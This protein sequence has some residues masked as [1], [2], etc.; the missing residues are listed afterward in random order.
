MIGSIMNNVIRPADV[1]L[2]LMHTNEKYW[3]YRRQPTC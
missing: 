2:F 3:Y 1:Q